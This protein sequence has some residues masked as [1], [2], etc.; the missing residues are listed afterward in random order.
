MNLFFSSF[1]PLLDFASASPSSPGSVKSLQMENLIPPPRDLQTDE[2]FHS[3]QRVWDEKKHL[4]SASGFR[5]MPVLWTVIHQL[6]F[7]EFWYGGFCRL[8]SDALVLVGPIV[9]ELVVRAA[10][11][12]DKWGIFYY[13]TILLISSLLQ[14]FLLTPPPAYPHMSVGNLLATIYRLK[15]PMRSQSH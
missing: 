1:Q 3:F 2:L 6:I 8:V 5:K 9:I 11:N 12:S 15:F 7:W 14:V 4:S 10:Q 13:S